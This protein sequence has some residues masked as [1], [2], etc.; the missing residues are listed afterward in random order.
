MKISKVSSSTLKN[1]YKNAGST[2]SKVISNNEGNKMKSKENINQIRINKFP[3][4]KNSNY[5]RESHDI[6]TRVKSRLNVGLNLDKSI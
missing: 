6:N 5:E 1:F 2:F 3:D 4:F